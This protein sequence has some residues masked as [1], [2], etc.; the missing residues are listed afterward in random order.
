MRRIASNW[1]ERD[2]RRRPTPPPTISSG[3]VKRNPVYRWGQAPLFIP[4]R[5]N[6]STTEARGRLT[7][8]RDSF[9]DKM[10]ALKWNAGSCHSIW[11]QVRLIRAR[12]IFR[13]QLIWAGNRLNCRYA[14][15][16]M[17]AATIRCRP[18]FALLLPGCKLD[19]RYR[20]IRIS[21]GPRATGVV[22][23]TS[24]SRPRPHGKGL[25]WRV[26]GQEFNQ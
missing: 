5:G 21:C 19:G 12:I 10:S 14:T 13:L 25:A 22:Y 9:A 24:L 11:G 7:N 23:S 3:D 8:L 17:R 20:W 16:R 26:I 6:Y 18:V 1:L 4:L 2:R 15:F